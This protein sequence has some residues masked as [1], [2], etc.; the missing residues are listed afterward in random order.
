MV[1]TIPPYTRVRY[2][3]ETAS[4]GKKRPRPVDKWCKTV[5]KAK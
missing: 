3:K 5:D 1:T 4:E 2:E